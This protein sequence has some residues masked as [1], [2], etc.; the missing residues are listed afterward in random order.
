MKDLENCLDALA[1]A[2][3]LSSLPS[4]LHPEEDFLAVVYLRN[5]SVVLITLR[6]YRG[7]YKSIIEFS[8]LPTVNLK[9]H[10][11][12]FFHYMLIYSLGKKLY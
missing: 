2:L 7:N 4:G 8:V 12:G 10:Q 1:L 3:A 5:P 9:T 6:S 11:V